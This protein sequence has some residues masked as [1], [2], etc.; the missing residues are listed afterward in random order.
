MAEMACR[1]AVWVL[2]MGNRGK[3]GNT[4]MRQRIM[5]Q[6]RTTMLQMAKIGAENGRK[7]W[8]MI[9]CK[10]V[11]GGGEFLRLQHRKKVSC[12]DFG[13]D[14][15]L[16]LGYM[17]IWTLLNQLNRKCKG[18]PRNKFSV[19]VG[20]LSFWGLSSTLS[21]KCP[22]ITL[23]PSFGLF[24]SEKWQKGVPGAAQC[25]SMAQNMPLWPLY[26]EKKRKSAGT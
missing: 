6:R 20:I 24:Q 16:L 25:G 21:W 23:S 5:C 11:W 19:K 2:E 1:R 18:S 8:C 7:R 12:M 17:Y 14:I 4:S 26:T 9:I 15:T 3:R 10:M 22:H 13:H